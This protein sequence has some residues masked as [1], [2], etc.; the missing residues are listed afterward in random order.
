ML[1]YFERWNEFNAENDNAGSG[2]TQF[3]AQQLTFVKG[4]TELYESDIAWKKAQRGPVAMLDRW[5]ASAMLDRW[6]VKANTR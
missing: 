2:T 6:M 1:Y 4:V 5:V 3:I